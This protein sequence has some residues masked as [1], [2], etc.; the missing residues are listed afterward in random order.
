MGR[1]AATSRSAR[2]STAVV[3][4]LF[5]AALGVSLYSV[6][7]G[8]A[9]DFPLLAPVAWV[10]LSASVGLLGC[11]WLCERRA[12][13]VRQ[14]ELLAERDAVA[15]HF[16]H[17]GLHA[18]DA[19]LLTDAEF[20]IVEANSRAQEMYGYT[21]AEFRDITARELRAPGAAKEFEPD[22]ESWTS[23]GIVY[24]TV[25][26]RKDGS[27][28]PV[29]ISGRLITVD[30][31]DFHHA[32][33]R[34]ITKRKATE[35]ALQESELRWR[36]A[37]EAGGDGIC[38]FDVSS[39]RLTYS[40]QTSQLLGYEPGRLPERLEDAWS[41]VHPLDRDAVRDGLTCLLSGARVSEWQE[42][43]VRHADGTYRWLL[44][45]AA[46]VSR[47]PN[48]SPA[49][50]I[51]VLTDITDRKR[52]EVEVARLTGLY[53]MLSRAIE[54]I[55]HATGP[56]DLF[57]TLCN[58]VAREQAF[59]FCVVMA[60]DAETGLLRLAAH[61][62]EGGAVLDGLRLTTSPDERSGLGPSGRAVRDGR[63]C[64]IND[65][66]NDPTARQWSERWVAQGFKSAVAFPILRGG[67]PAASFTLFSDQLGFF[68]ARVFSLLAK[69]TDDAS[70][71]LD[72]FAADEQ[73]HEVQQ[74]LEQALHRQ[75]L[76][77]D[78]IPDQAWLKDA[79]GR[80][81]QVN[82][83]YAD[84]VGLSPAE[85]VGKRDEDL[86]PDDMVS[87]FRDNDELA[88]SSCGTL[89]REVSIRLP[90]GGEL[91]A[92]V[93]I[94][95]LMDAEGG[96]GGTVGVAR[97]IT[98]NKR[99]EIERRA[100]AARLEQALVET[101]QAISMTVEK[102]D[103]YTSGHQ[104]RVAELAVDIGREMGLDQ[105][106]IEGLRLGGMIHDIGKIAVPAEI[107]NRPGR[108]SAIEMELIRAHAEIG[109]DIVKDV[110]FPWPV[111]AMVR[112]H[113]ER[114]DGSG[115]PQGLKGEEIVL[116]ARIIAVADV[117]E[118]ISA[119]RPYRPAMGVGKALEEIRRGRDLLYDARAV[120]ACLSLFDRGR[121]TFDETI[122]RNAG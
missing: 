95:P 2:A 7:G 121:Y 37:L 94:A 86:W 47:K 118:A 44:F 92:D 45:R 24:E 50:I 110:E 69:L 61:A 54:A 8:P 97:D 6:A 28:F 108:L 90:K 11:M 84:A 29:E 66:A 113:H 20:R 93:S 14:R 111:A 63:P 3:G 119:H 81:L 89:R 15:S 26:R 53:R 72:K 52:D 49:R 51:A 17:I 98:E 39:G 77:L 80:L 104:H 16:Q 33:V 67:E 40:L 19:F 12:S 55:V 46:V 71:A 31:H 122:H 82:R 30:G 13:T 115:Y 79:D 116:E 103:P 56:Q 4:S 73:S 100:H 88:K 27:E 62:G 34:D 76:F 38:D 35:Q 91:E 10:L 96:F 60:R 70:F 42:A 102:R 22:Y 18:N 83:A 109:Y 75:R 114:L 5:T 21:A 101:I 87:V 64:I 99:F 25:H 41:F 74:R 36:F 107:L 106:R 105:S 65:L 23:D 32:T 58:V 120:D 112:Q 59:R 117:V 1:I 48:G 68:D 57:Q 9:G 43:R 78:T 85:V